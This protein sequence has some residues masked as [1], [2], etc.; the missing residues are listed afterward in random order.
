MLKN[1]VRLALAK[2]GLELRRL[3]RTDRLRL[4]FYEPGDFTKKPYYNVGASSFSHPCWTNIDFAS[5]WYSSHQTAFINHNLMT[6]EPLPI[7][8]GVAKVIYTSHTIEHV[9]EAAVRKL[10]SEAYRCLRPGGFLRI[11]APNAENDYAALLRGDADWFQW[12]RVMDRPGTYEHAYRQPCS[13]V[14]LEEQWLD[15][16]AT[17]LGPN[18]RSPSARKFSASEIREIIGSMSMERALDYFT[19]MCEFQDAWPGSH[20]SWWTPTKVERFVRE[21]GFTKVHRSAHWQ[22]FCPAM[23][24]TP[25]FDCS[26]P[27]LSLYVEAMR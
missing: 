7:E 16:V 6:L 23:R 15:Q 19:G 8:S 26:L 17:Q 24:L 11:V 3:D 22:S 13:S 21:A 12:N 20:I 25:L 9:S 18:H 5:E 27:E 10:L 1:T 2:A 14:P 4:R